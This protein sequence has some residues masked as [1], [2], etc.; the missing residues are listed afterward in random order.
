LTNGRS[1][2]RRGWLPV[3]S[4]AEQPAQSRA[5]RLLEKG[6]RRVARPRNSAGPFE[7]EPCPRLAWV[8]I[9]REARRV[10][11]RAREYAVSHDPVGHVA[12]H[13]QG[14]P[15]VVREWATAARLCSASAPES[16]GLR[17]VPKAT[18]RRAEQSLTTAHRTPTGATLA[19]RTGLRRFSHLPGS[20]REVRGRLRSKR[21]AGG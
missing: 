17:S 20:V 3:A 14:A 9:H 16:P 13:P 7:H 10:R 1:P 11:R 18:S 4:S 19:K 12:E 15:G 21:A 5:G 8:T 2:W 6:T